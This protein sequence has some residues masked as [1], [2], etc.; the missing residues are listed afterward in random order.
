M[1]SSE[2]QKLMESAKL[3]EVYTNEND[4]SKF[5]VGFI[6]ACDDEYFIMLT[7][8]KFGRLDGFV[9]Q[10]VDSIVRISEDTVYL[11]KIA[12]LMRYY[13]EKREKIT[14]DQYPVYDLLEYCRANN[15]IASIDLLG[16]EY[17][18]AKGYIEE[19]DYDKCVVRQV[20]EE[21]K[22]DGAT[23]IILKD[24]SFISCCSNI[25]IMLEILNSEL[26]DEMHS[27]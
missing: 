17:S 12:T 22:N 15:R 10:E 8:T 21:G 25:E 23:S 6:V 7:V 9:L 14:V 19:L 2:L 5:D 20:S 26:F 13:N 4:T 1:F 18:D 3:V 27:N 16:S 24:I 11:R